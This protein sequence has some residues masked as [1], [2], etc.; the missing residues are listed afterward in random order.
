MHK[1]I[2]GLAI[3]SM[4][5]F[6]TSFLVQPALA[7]GAR[8][9]MGK[10]TNES[11]NPIT[12]AE[13]RMTSTDGSSKY[14]TKTDKRGEFYYMG[15]NFG[16]YYV[17]ARAPG[18]QPD[19]VQGIQ[20]TIAQETVVNFK[21]KAGDDRKLPFEMSSAEREQ[22]KEAASKAEKLLKAS[23]EVKQAFDEGLQLAQQ[24]KYDEAVVSYKK[25]LGLDP[26]QAYILANMADALAKLDKNEDALAAYEKAVALQ[27]GDSALYTNMGV[28]L[29]KL[30]KTAESQEAFKKAAALSP[31]SAAQNLYNLGAT[32]VNSGKAA[33]A[34][35][36]FRQALKADESYAE[37]WYQLG[38]CLSGNQ[39]TM[40]EAI[41][42]LERYI[43]IGQK[44][45]EVE[46]AKQLI[47]ALQSQVGK[48]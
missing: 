38:I 36:A 41:R 37:A 43:K 12:G 28:V 30:G 26:S 35:E 23:A 47:T 3:L 29:G 11:G 32:L 48:K 40:P 8:V 18:Y 14:S 13:V 2:R 5:L 34:A 42:A 7:Q 33:E 1:R 19:F 45:D 9:I 4:A 15:V 10:V 31:G 6:L 44:Q 25:A 46:V 27:P 21:L 20:P 16:N 22:A 39:A 17:V 24:G